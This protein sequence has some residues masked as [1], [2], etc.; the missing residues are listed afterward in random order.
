MSLHSHSLVASV[1]SIFIII[2]VATIKNISNHQYSD[3][4]EH[5]M[6]GVPAHGGTTCVTL[7]RVQC[8]CMFCMC[9]TCRTHRV[10]KL[11]TSISDMMSPVDMLMLLTPALR[12]R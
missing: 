4:G 5:H 9:V 2:E 10:S 3:T 7:H 8:V 6:P 12:A 1:L 11:N